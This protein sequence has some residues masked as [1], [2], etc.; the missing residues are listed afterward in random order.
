MEKSDIKIKKYGRTVLIC[1]D[2]PESLNA[3]TPSTVEALNQAI[4]EFENDNE[5]WTAVLTGGGKKSLCVGADLKWMASNPDAKRED[6]K[7]H[8]GIWKKMTEKPIIAAVNGYCLGGGFEIALCCDLIIAATNAIFG[9]PE[10]KNAGSFPGDGGPF[11]LPRQIPQ[12][13]AMDMLLTDMRLSSKEALRLGLINQI[14]SSDDLLNKALEK[15]EQINKVPP[16]AVRLTRNLVYSSL[17]LPLNEPEDTSFSSWDL[18]NDAEKKLHQSD[19]WKSGEG[20]KSFLEK[21]DANWTGK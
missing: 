2:R 18:Y 12:R 3:F 11:R 4:D 9:L 16:I 13:I 6:W 10:L 15:A 1:I 5:L 21:R 19:D 8:K 17:D 20:P 7:T 14:V